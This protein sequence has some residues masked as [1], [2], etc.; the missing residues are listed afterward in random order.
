MVNLDLIRNLATLIIADAKEVLPAKGTDEAEAQEEAE[1]LARLPDN[2]GR[3]VVVLM[4]MA[5]CT[6]KLIPVHWEVF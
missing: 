1:R 3:E 4:A 6:I 5:S 2:I